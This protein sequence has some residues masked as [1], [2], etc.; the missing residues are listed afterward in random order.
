MSGCQ[1]RIVIVTFALA[2]RYAYIILHVPLAGWT[3]LAIQLNDVSRH[4]STE[5]NHE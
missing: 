3:A 2:G 4:I 5:S 1:E